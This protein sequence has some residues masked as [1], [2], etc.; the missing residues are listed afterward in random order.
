M[1]KYLKTM[2]GLCFYDGNQV[3]TQR[4]PRRSHV[5]A[6]DDLCAHE[7]FKDRKP[8]KW[9]E[10]SSFPFHCMRLRNGI[11]LMAKVK[12]TPCISKSVLQP[13]F[14]LLPLR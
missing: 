11:R 9:Y 13:S 6:N 10:S 1:D 8:A 4:L 7:C 5:K 12:L 3:R 14:M 2:Q